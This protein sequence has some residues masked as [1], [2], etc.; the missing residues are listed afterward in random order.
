[1][2]ININSNIERAIHDM[3]L[4]TVDASFDCFGPNGPFGFKVH[5]G[6]NKLWMFTLY[7]Q[8]I[9]PCLCRQFYI[10][11]SYKVD[12]TLLQLSKVYLCESRLGLLRG[13]LLC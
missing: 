2:N 12:Q 7:S 10:K 4:G 11:M 3:K 1:M 6:G 8:I 5:L 13:N 9:F